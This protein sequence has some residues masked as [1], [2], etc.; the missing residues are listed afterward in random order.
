MYKERV[1]SPQEKEAMMKKRICVSVVLLGAFLLVTSLAPV[2]AQEGR[3]I[4]FPEKWWPSKWGAQ[5]E[6]GS[7]NTI[8]PQKIKSSLKYVR[9]GKV[10]RLGLPY[11]QGMPLVGPRTYGLHI[12]GLPANNPVGKIGGVWNTEYVVG[13][14]GQI[15]TQFDAPGH[16]GIT[17]PDGVMR[18]YNGRELRNPDN[19]YGLKENG[20]E[21]LGP[22]VTRGVLIDMVGLK[23]RNMEK[24]EVI[25]VADMEA[26]IKKAGIEPIGDGDAVIFNTGWGSYWDDPDTYG[27]GCPGPGAEVA[28][29]LVKKNISMVGGDTWPVEVIPSEHPDYFAQVHYFMQTVHGIWFIENLNHDSMAE[30][31]KDGAYD[32]L[33]IYIP[34]PFTGATGS[35]GEPIAIR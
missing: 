29:Y 34:V 16:T 18:W 12:I 14:I 8:T 23:G 26:C 4:T 11:E 33:W 7:F 9:T 30:M 10:Y 31:A 19:A 6:K 15:G 20:V 2:L 5:D 35:P 28:E 1:L 24:G 25:T 22:C 32:F 3:T 17:W 27:A 13:E 21:K